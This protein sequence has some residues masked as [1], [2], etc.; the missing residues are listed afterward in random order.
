MEH[1]VQF[2]IGIDDEA[3]KKQVKVSGYK[4]VING[5]MKEAKSGLVGTP[6]ASENYLGR[7]EINWDR[8]LEAKMKEFMEKNK[9]VIIEKAAEKL[10]ESYRRTKKFKEAAGQVL[11]G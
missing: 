1:I 7:V 9:D 4:D 5:L 8:V 10:A 3:I 6:Y 11:G 2:A